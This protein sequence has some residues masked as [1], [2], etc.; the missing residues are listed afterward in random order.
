MLLGILLF[1]ETINRNHIFKQESNGVR[2]QILNL[3][4]GVH[5][6]VLGSLARDGFIVFRDGVLSMIKYKHRK[7]IED[8]IHCL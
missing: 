7:H 5:C 6:V 8:L 4:I 3:E 2:T 1:Y